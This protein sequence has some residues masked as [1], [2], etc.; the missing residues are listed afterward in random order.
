MI[1]V[2]FNKTI[3]EQDQN[4][5][6]VSELAEELPGIFNWAYEEL[7]SLQKYG[8]SIPVKCRDAI[9]Q[10]KREEN[11]ARSFLEDN[12]AY[13]PEFMG[14]PTQDLYR[15]YRKW[16]QDNGYRSLNSSNFGKEVKRVYPKARKVRPRSSED[17]KW[18]YSGIYVEPES[19][20]KEDLHS[21]IGATF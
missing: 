15:A 7:A 2:P 16:C 11:P 1:Y 4:K 13:H 9:K 18:C 6:L 5:N 10:Y 20:I 3:P 12:F 21:E 17:R 19:E 14:V 8:F